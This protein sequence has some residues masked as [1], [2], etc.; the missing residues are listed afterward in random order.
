[1]CHRFLKAGERPC[2]FRSLLA[3]AGALLLLGSPAAMADEAPN[4][5]T[6]PFNL[7]I[8][9]FILSSDIEARLDGESGRGTTVDWE[10]TL[11]DDADQTQF[12]IDGFWR[13]A[14]RHKVRML[15]FSNTTSN[16]RT[17]DEEIDW[18]DATYPVDAEIKSEFSFDIYEL[19]YEYAFLRRDNY[20]LSGTIGLHW[21]TLSAELKGE[22]SF[23]GGE[24]VSGTVR[25]EGSVDLP[26]PVIGLRGLWSLS[27]GFW[28]DAS[29]QF[30]A[31]SIDEYDG[32]LQDYRVAVLWQ[33]KR[34]LGV[35]VGYN[36]FSVDVDVEQD[37]FE[38]NIDWTYKGPILFYSASF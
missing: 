5:L 34:W 24:P 3:C 1:M 26:L 28:I 4:L 15:W 22:A 8:G 31:L 7:A 17:L 33:P 18:G 9:T 38:G 19:A 11:G 14:D 20:E 10:R 36:Q 2:D 29:A 37:R 35:G 30:F 16:K 12:R 27:H 13:F 21:A 32:S 6:D 25:S 23:V